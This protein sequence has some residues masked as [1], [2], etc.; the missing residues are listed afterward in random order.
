V[1]GNYRWEDL[2]GLV[3]RRLEADERRICDRVRARFAFLA[4][5]RRDHL[6]RRGVRGH[7]H[8]LR[9]AGITVLHDMPLPFPLG[10]WRAEFVRRFREA[11]P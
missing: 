10:N 11:L 2:P 1:P 4:G 8:H 3:P 9:T 5:G 7:R 6:P